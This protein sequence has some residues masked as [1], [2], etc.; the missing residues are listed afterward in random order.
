MTKGGAGESRLSLSDSGGKLQGLL[1]G[2][3][4]LLERVTRTT[5][6]IL[7]VFVGGFPCENLDLKPQRAVLFRGDKYL[8]DIFI[9][10]LLADEPL[11]GIP[12]SLV[13]HMADGFDLLTEVLL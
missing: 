8:V 1:V 10:K 5:S 4:H 12:A 7:E 2:L 9:Y 11:G 6:E 13:Q 3:D